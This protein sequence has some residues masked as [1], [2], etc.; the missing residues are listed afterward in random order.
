MGALD[1]LEVEDLLDRLEQ[2]LGE[3]EQFDPEVRDV[4]FTLLDGFDRLHRVALHRLAAEVGGSAVERARAADGAVAW[5]LH[6]YGVGV[7]DE[8]AAAEAALDDV[9]PYI[10][11]HGGRVEVLDATNGVV[12]L[13]LS[14][15]CSGCTSSAVTLRE[16]VEKALHER[17]PGFAGMAVE[18]DDAAAHPPPGATLLQITSRPPDLPLPLTAQST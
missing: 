11:S 2:L 6:A 5:L 7:D 18:E 1:E 13:R 10:E 12:R 9:R 16:G 8:V 4:V 14:G 17:F 3:V 15:T